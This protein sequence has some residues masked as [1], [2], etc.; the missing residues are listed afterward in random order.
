M[1]G[2]SE[3]MKNNASGKTSYDRNGKDDDD[4]GG[5]V[6]DD[7][8]VWRDS[9][10]RQEELEELFVASS[11]QHQEPPSSSMG[12]GG[13]SRSGIL[14][15]P[16]ACCRFGAWMMFLSVAVGVSVAIYGLAKKSQSEQFQ[17]EVRTDQC[18]VIGRLPY[19]LN[20][21]K[22]STIDRA[23]F[24][25]GQFDYQATRILDTATLR[26]EDFWRQLENM[27]V[28]FSAQAQQRGFASSASTCWPFC[29]ISDYDFQVKH[30]LLMVEDDNEE[31]EGTT[32]RSV[33]RGPVLLAV[34]VDP[35]ED[36]SAWEEYSR[37]MSPRWL[38]ESLSTQT[39][40]FPIPTINTKI[41]HLQDDATSTGVNNN[42]NNTRGS[43]LHVPYNLSTTQQTLWP[44]WMTSLPQV[45]SSTSAAAAAIEIVNYDLMDD[46]IYRDFLIPS[47]HN[48]DDIIFLSR[49]MLRATMEESSNIAQV[50]SY[51]HQGNT[52]EKEEEWPHSIVAVPIYDTTTF[53]KKGLPV[54]LL[55]LQLAWH[56]LFEDIWKTMTKNEFEE[57][58]S[59]ELTMEDSC[60]GRSFRYTL[61]PGDTQGMEYQ[62]T[63]SIDE[64]R[65][66]P[67]R[68]PSLSRAWDQIPPASGNSTTTT[69]CPL[70]IRLEASRQ[71]Y[72]ESIASKEGTGSTAIIYALS[73][74]AI[75]VFLGIVFWCYDRTMNNP[76]SG[77]SLQGKPI[78]AIKTSFTSTTQDGD[79]EDDTAAVKP[80]TIADLHPNVTIL[81]ADIA[82]FAVGWTHIY[83]NEISSSSSSS[84]TFPFV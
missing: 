64:M 56:S 20:R 5:S 78:G 23:G 63:G 35:Q 62:G 61:V 16:R 6:D 50:A 80:F 70:Q 41:Y 42:N 53:T 37:M 47:R 1:D 11:L 19:Y 2:A 12:G 31:E 39:R 13:A 8:T 3:S 24:F 58:A 68:I 71:W 14:R 81:H 4:D 34:A 76:R 22:H 54:A 48:D 59:L 52:N 30:H 82:N 9:G 44:V 26:L 69:T 43:S 32:T 29:T 46:G 83:Q 21:N 55:S 74:M 28:S 45:V 77:T 36:G 7:S 66:T 17:R 73:S 51:H 40:T 27:R 75:F 79:E 57:N 84:L 65:N 49:P 10:G 33:G 15:P 72:D 18:T 67:S 38:L 60:T 25:L